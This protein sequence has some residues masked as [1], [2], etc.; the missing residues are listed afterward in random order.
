MRLHRVKLSRLLVAMD[1]SASAEAA[2]RSAAQLAPRLNGH[3]VLVHAFDPSASRREQV[4]GAG[5]RAGRRL[6]DIVSA[7]QADR[8]IS[9]SV[10]MPGDP[11]E[12]ILDQAKRVRADLIVMGTNGRRGV[13]RL[14]LGSVAE[15]VVRR[16]GCPVLVVKVRGKP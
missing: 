16:A 14:V 5:H 11:V 12:V 8:V 7:S 13:Q 15:S 9:G 10:V 4:D 2:L 6:E 3:A 1:F